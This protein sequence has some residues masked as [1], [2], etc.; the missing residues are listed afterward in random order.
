MKQILWHHSGSSPSEVVFPVCIF[1]LLHLVPWLSHCRLLDFSIV[2]ILRKRGK[3]LSL[4][5]SNKAL[6]H[7][8]VWGSGCI[9]PRFLDL[10]TSW[11]GQLYAPAA[12]PPVPI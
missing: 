11:S 8:E 6:R 12:L 7:E 4:C 2:T 5:L 3:S 9:N 10:G 1:Y